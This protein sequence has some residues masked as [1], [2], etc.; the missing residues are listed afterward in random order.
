MFIAGYPCQ[1][2]SILN[3]SRY[4]A[5]QDPTSKPEAQVLKSVVKMIG[6]LTP[7]AFLLEN[8]QGI[9]NVCS[10]GKPV[11]VVQ[12]VTETIAAELGSTYDFEH[13]VIPSHRPSFRKRTYTIGVRKDHDVGLGQICEDLQKLQLYLGAT[14]KVHHLETC[15]QTTLEET[16]SLDNDVAMDL[17]QRRARYEAALEKALGKAI[18]ANRLP[19]NVRVPNLTTFSDFGPWMDAQIMVS[20]AY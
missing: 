13:V 6:K 12:W 10:S 2:N 3:P 9:H 14:P 20:A 7:L 18:E 4:D 15:L 1:A 11:P 16:P 8:V 5:T 19:S 17:A